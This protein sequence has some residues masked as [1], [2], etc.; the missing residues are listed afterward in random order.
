MESSLK[1]KISAKLERIKKYEAETPVDVAV[2]AKTLADDYKELGDLYLKA[3]D[4]KS[5]AKA[6]KKAEESDL[7]FVKSEFSYDKAFMERTL[8][9][10][11]AYWNKVMENLKK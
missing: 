4:S 8:K 9:E 11:K 10:R 6:F 7:K 5:A 1:S 3:A 2:I